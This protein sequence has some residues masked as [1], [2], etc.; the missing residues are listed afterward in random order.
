MLAQPPARPAASCAQAFRPGLTLETYPGACKFDPWFLEQ[1]QAI[2]AAETG[3][4]VNGLPGDRA[5]SGVE[6]QWAFSDATAG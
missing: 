1:I 6:T 4:R 5:D 2:V 3:F